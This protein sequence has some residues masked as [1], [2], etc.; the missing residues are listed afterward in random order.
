MRTCPGRADAL[1]F[2]VWAADGDSADSAAAPAPARRR[3]ARRLVRN[4]RLWFIGPS[5]L[6]VRGYDLTVPGTPRQTAQ[7][8]AFTDVQAGS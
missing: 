1:G 4:E 3:N 8:R 2:V 5:S 7:D 6:T